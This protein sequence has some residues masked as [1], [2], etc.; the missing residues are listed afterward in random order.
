MGPLPS[1]SF[2]A[3]WFELPLAVSIKYLG[4]LLETQ[5]CLPM[6]LGNLRAENV[7][8]KLRRAR[9]I[10]C[11]QVRHQLLGSYLQG[12]YSAATSACKRTLNSL[13]AA[14]VQAWWGPTLHP[15]NTMRSRAVTLG[16]FNAIQIFCPFAAMCYATI[17]ALA[18]LQAKFPELARSIWL[19]RFC[20]WQKLLGFSRQVHRC[21]QNLGILWPA[22]HII[23]FEDGS[24]CDLQHLLDS[25]QL[26]SAALHNL[27][28]ALRAHWWRSQSPLRPCLD[29]AGAGIDRRTTL[30]PVRAMASSNAWCGNDGTGGR[31]YKRFLANALWSR[32]RLLHS[33]RIQ[34]GLCN[35]CRLTNEST[36]HLL[37]GCVA[38]S[39]ALDKL[40]RAWIGIEPSCNFDLQLADL[41]AC[42]RMCG[43]VPLQLP[44]G[45]TLKHVTALQCYFVAI[46]AEWGR[47]RDHVPD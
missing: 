12:L 23:R 37:W 22:F 31:R 27:R 26:G 41:P 19:S 21:L 6:Q 10:P 7:I 43:L 18:R 15:K 2:R 36:E 8:Q 1:D 17:L 5:P 29:G 25:S 20:S 38:N 39:M 16:L 9:L 4:T 46:L 24:A 44:P 35:R 40:K 14:V 28:E 30:A 33:G 32:V 11:E 13:E 45:L 34:C 47:S 3:S 42:L